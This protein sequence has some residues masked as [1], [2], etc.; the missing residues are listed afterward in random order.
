MT[1]VHG[2]GIGRYGGRRESS[3]LYDSSARSATGGRALARITGRLGYSGKM[4]VLC[5]PCDP[6]TQTG[7]SGSELD[8]WT[9]P[10]TC[11]IPE[12]PSQNFARLR[13][14]TPEK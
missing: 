6:Q 14:T 12:S 7:F 5:P 4:V 11:G 3:K 1:T 2:L 8:P 13:Y 9:V 10:L